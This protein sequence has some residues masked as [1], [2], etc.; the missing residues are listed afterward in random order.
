MNAF[1]WPPYILSR[2]KRKYGH[3][4]NPYSR[5][6]FCMFNGSHLEVKVESTRKT[7]REDSQEYR[8]IRSEGDENKEMEKMREGEI[9]IEREEIK[10]T[11]G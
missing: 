1:K 6:T 4:P 3:A 9:E 8:D 5:V 11:K 2:Q 7:N 10:A